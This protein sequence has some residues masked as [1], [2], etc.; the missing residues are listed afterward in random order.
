MADQ[1]SKSTIFG[2]F[3]EKAKAKGFDLS[4]DRSKMSKVCP[5]NQ[6]LLE[7]I[8][9]AMT[10][11]LNNG[12]LPGTLKASSLKIGPSGLQQ[13]VA[14]KTATVKADIVSDSKFFTWMETL[15]GLLQAVYPEP[16]FGSP[17]TFAMALKTLLGMKPTSITAKI[18]QGSG[19]V[20]VTT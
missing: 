20:K 2:K 17:D 13:P 16:G 12:N 5:T 9:E 19:S 8:A 6:D 18:T 10:D 4:P 3:K 14:Y 7:A 15:H 11:I 1:Y